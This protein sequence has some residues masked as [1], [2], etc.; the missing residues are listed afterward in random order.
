MEELVETVGGGTGLGVGAAVVVGALVVVGGGA[1]ALTKGIIRLGLTT[2]N[3][4]RDWTSAARQQVG[5]LAEEARAE[6]A[7]RTTSPP[8]PL[9]A[10]AAAA[11]TGGTAE[12]GRRGRRRRPASHMPSGTGQTPDGGARPGELVGPTGEPL[13]SGPAAA[14]RHEP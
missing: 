4:V 5:E 3:N 12:A 2:G 13:G 7:A 11:A 10:S 9:V 6:R 14:A 8:P 1:R